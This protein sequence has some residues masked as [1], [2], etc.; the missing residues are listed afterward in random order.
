MSA[1]YIGPKRKIDIKFGNIFFKKKTFKKKYKPVRPRKNYKKKPSVFIF[2]L[3]E[4]QKVKFI[5][6]ILEKQ[7]LKMFHDVYKK[8]GITGELLIQRCE[9]RLDN[10]VYRLKIA[11]TRPFARQLVAHKH[12]TVNGKVIN[13]PSY[14]IKPGDIISMKKKNKEF[15]KN[16]LSSKK[17]DLQDWLIWDKEKQNGI[18]QYIPKRSQIPE[19]IKENLIVELLHSK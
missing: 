3:F 9:S 14:I 13:I 19:K 8:K 15:V 18:F 4:K 10:V 17:D 12:I 2:Q 1:R 16:L 11:L 6:G 7:F 5:Y